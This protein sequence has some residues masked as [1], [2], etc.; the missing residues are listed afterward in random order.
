[1]KHRGLVLIL[2]IA[3]ILTMAIP[4]VLAVSADK[5]GTESNMSVDSVNAAY[6]KLMAC[7]SIS[8]M[9][10]AIAGVDDE[11]ASLFT[12]EQISSVEAKI[13]ALLSESST[14][15]EAIEDEQSESDEVVQS[16]T[17]QPTVNYTNV[18]PFVEPVTGEEN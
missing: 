12:E 9:E 5:D 8:E 17:V 14:T 16:V 18:A 1:M 4:G 11:T 6:E 13:E 3:L 10:A 15:Y 2:S 7:E